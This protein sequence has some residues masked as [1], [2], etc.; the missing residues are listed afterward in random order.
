[1]SKRVYAATQLIEELEYT[2]SSKIE[3]NY[4]NGHHLR[5]VIAEFAVKLLR[6]RWEE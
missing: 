3:K 4:R 1:M 6:E 5:Q 2:K